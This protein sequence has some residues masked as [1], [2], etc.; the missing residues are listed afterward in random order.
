MLNQL[1]K[2]NYILYFIFFSFTFSTINAQN[3]SGQIKVGT[4][5][6]D[7]NFW[8]SEYNNF[9]F[10]SYSTYQKTK[11]EMD[12]SEVELVLN[13]FSSLN[14]IKSIS[15]N[16][17]YIK[18]PIKEDSFFKIGRY[19]RDFSTYIN[20]ELSSGSILISNNAQAMPK[21]GIISHKYIKDKRISFNYGIAHGVFDKNNIYSSSPLL[22]EKFIYLNINDD[23][24]IYTI[25][26]VHE[27]IWGGTINNNEIKNN[28][29]SA[30]T[31]PERERKKRPIV[32]GKIVINMK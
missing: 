3:L 23:N 2:N 26:F 30:C 16:E 20:D 19:Y 14:D 24:T 9:G 15:L 29:D 1:K 13:I 32:T 17:S 10:E 7:S 12:N 21:A 22:H 18:V 11:I 31:R 27:A 4:N 5:P 25:G 8:W 6:S 28:N